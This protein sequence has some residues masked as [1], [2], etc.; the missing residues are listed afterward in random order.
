MT[1][2]LTI[3]AH[4]ENGNIALDAPL[5]KNIEWV[6]VRARVSST[7]GSAKARSVAAYLESLPPGNRTGEE[8]DRQVQAERDSWP[9]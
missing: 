3:P 4:V 1:E 8:I 9:E 6:E 5:P 7:P 2:T